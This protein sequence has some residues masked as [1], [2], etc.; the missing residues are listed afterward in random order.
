MKTEILR[1]LWDV[2]LT[3]LD[4]IDRICK[5]HNITY[6]LM[7][8]TL[9]GAVRHK[10]FIPW[11]DDVDVTMPQKDYFRFLKIAKKEL[12]DSMFLQTPFTDNYHPVYFSKVRMN[13][14][15]F[16]SKGDTNHKKHHGIFVDVFPFYESKSKDSRL[17]RL[18]RKIVSRI[19]N[20]VFAVRQGT[21]GRN[22]VLSLF[23]TSLLIRLYTRLLRG[24]GNV[25]LCEGRYFEGN[26]FASSTTL[27]FE[28]KEYPVPKDYD[29]VL[30]SI[31]GDYMQLPPENERV[32]HLPS[33]I[34]FDTSKPDEVVD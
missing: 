22:P 32:A 20:H 33:K 31:Y 29:K 8:G 21:T 24:K 19:Q 18:K 27:T 10:G 2:E 13:G 9:L 23:P 1:R 17:H 25:W 6:H 16:Y 30:R 15:E 11:D 12:P 26:D 14:T 4:E 7:W 34:S 3:I 28:G 5:K